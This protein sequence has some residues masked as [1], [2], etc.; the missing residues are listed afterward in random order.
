MRP[1]G[2]DEDSIEEIE[3]DSEHEFEISGNVLM[4]QLWDLSSHMGIKTCPEGSVCLTC[5]RSEFLPPKA[6]K[7]I[8]IPYKVVIQGGLS[9]VNGLH[10]PRLVA[11]LCITKGGMIRTSVF[12]SLDETIQLVPKTVLVIIFAATVSVKR[13]GQK[14]KPIVPRVLMMIEEA[15]MSIEQQIRES[16]PGVGDLSSHPVN[17]EMAETD[18][19]TR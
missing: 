2:E 7:L 14:V 15:A 16:F 11:S 4:E 9:I 8:Y 5:T 6:W 17:E 1:V 13:F 18:C 10:K 19:E 12:N 3:V